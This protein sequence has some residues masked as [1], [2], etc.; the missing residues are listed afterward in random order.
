MSGHGSE[1]QSIGARALHDF[2]ST[3]TGAG[4]HVGHPEAGDPYWEV[5]PAFVNQP[6]LLF[7]WIAQPG[8]ATSFPN[9]NGFESGHAN[10]VGS[11]FYGL[12]IGVAP[13]VEHVDNYEAQFFF[14]NFVQEQAVIPAR[15]V[16]QSFIMSGETATV[17]LAYDHY[18]DRFGT[19]FVSGIGNGGPVNAPATCY[20]GIGVGAYGGSSSTGPTIDGRSKPDIAAPGSATSYSTPLVA[21]AAAILLQAALRGDAGSGT[22]MAASDVRT[23]KAIILNGAQKT[24]GWTHSQTTPLDPN[25]GAGILNVYNSYG[26]LRGGQHGPVSATTV[27]LGSPHPP[28]PGATPTR[29]RRGWDFN[30]ISSSVT[31]DAVNHYVFEVTAAAPRV[32]TFTSTLVWH[33]QNGENTINDLNLFLYNVDNNVLV[34]SSESL[35]DNIEHIYVTE[36]PPGRYN[37]QVFKRGGPP[38]A[39]VSNGETYGLAFEFGPPEPAELSNAQHADALFSARLTGEPEHTYLV[40]RTVDFVTWSP[41]LTNT[42]SAP[43]FFDFSVA[44]TGGDA[45]YRALR[46]P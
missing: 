19:L 36:L 35:V 5:N 33:R 42:T 40:Q 4:V 2:D 11:F 9:T 3:L 39:I 38:V 21:G 31:R 30:N 29:L 24:M 43:G 1:L 6:E 46:A 22:S 8:T 17:D 26:Q 28:P 34:M 23:V 37:L 14:T 27:S 12:G 25:F 18:A 13:G 44:E 41:A 32:F 45:F 20:N 15:V 7:T 10:Q 16:N